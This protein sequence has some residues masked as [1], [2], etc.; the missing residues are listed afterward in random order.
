[1]L[2][3][4]AHLPGIACHYEGQL[5][6]RPNERPFVMTRPTYAG[7][8]RKNKAIVLSQPISWYVNQG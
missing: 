3:P 1:L 8:Q 6:L 7:G 5:A 4:S 2:E